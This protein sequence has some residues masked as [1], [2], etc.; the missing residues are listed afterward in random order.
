[1]ILH[2][3]ILTPDLNYRNKQVFTPYAKPHRDG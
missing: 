3:C 1:M 2:G